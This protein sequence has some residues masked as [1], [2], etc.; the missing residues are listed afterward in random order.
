MKEVRNEKDE[1]EDFETVEE[2]T[3]VIYRKALDDIKN[4]HT[5]RARTDE[6]YELVKNEALKQKVSTHKLLAYLLARESYDTK[7]KFSQNMMRIFRGEDDQKSQVSLMQAVSIVSRGRMG[8]T[9]YNYVR[10]QLLKASGQ[11]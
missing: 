8:R 1:K 2:K 5:M 9:A 7:R 4:N 10:R 11:N 3:D 6:I